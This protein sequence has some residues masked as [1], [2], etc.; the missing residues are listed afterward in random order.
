M[1]F[2]LR[3]SVTRGCG[4]DGERQH[5]TSTARLLRHRQGMLRMRCQPGIENAFDARML[6]EPGQ[7]RLAGSESGSGYGPGH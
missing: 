4:L 2:A 7:R 5:R 1:G 3:G 6:L